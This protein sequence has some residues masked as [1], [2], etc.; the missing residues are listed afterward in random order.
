MMPVAIAH[1]EHIEKAIA[2]ALVPLPP[3]ELL[4]SFRANGLSERV[5]PGH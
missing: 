2:Q 3:E 5:N 1:H 4:R